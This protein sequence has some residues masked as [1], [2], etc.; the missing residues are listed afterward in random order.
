MHDIFSNTGAGVEVQGEVSKVVLRDNRIY[1]GND[2]GVLNSRWC[3]KM[4]MHLTP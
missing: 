3:E 4:P 1:D 2:D